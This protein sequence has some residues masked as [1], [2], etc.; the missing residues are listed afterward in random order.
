[1]FRFALGNLLSRPLRSILS[2]LGLAIAIAGMVGLFAIAGG[3]D[4]MVSRTF[5]QIPGLFVQQQGSPIPIFSTLPADWAEEIRRLPGVGAV[6][7]EVVGRAN[8]IE[9]KTIINPPRFLAGL[10]LAQRVHLKRDVYR[11]NMRDGRF[12]DDQ[13]RG[14]NRCVIS[15]DIAK[16]FQKKVGDTIV[17]NQLVFDI[18]GVYKTGSMVLDVN[19][20]VD[21]DTARSATRTSS[22]TVSSFYVE[23]ESGADKQQLKQAIE[24]QFRDR[25][26]SRVTSPVSQLLSG[27]GLSEAVIA[28]FRKFSQGN[29]GDGSAPPS[30]TNDGTAAPVPLRQVDASGQSTVEVRMAEDWSQR[31]EEFSGDLNIFLSLITTIGLAIAVLSI[32]NTMMMS[33]TERTTEFGILR[34]NGWS[35]GHIVRLMT[36]ESGLIGLCGGIVGT[37]LGVAAVRIINWNWSDRLQLY[38][39]PQLILFG[40]AFSTALG[41]CGGLYPAWVAARMSPMESIRRG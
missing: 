20:L 17:V 36:L 26:L 15:R 6:D 28:M 24:D 38:A 22:E 25:D 3:I 1:M 4:R 32:I 16:Q 35:Q 29:G 18:V 30:A 21:I 14:T 7:S 5:A 12:L 34:A 37:T 19:I 8:V 10:E 33:V 41:I 27:Q 31:L 13:D 40:I 2:L 11:E 23:P 9:G 39:G